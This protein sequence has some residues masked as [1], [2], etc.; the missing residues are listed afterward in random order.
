M[1]HGD[2]WALWLFLVR[3]ADSSHDLTYLMLQHSF[4]VLV[5][6][7]DYDPTCIGGW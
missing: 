1:S 5:L 4:I 7:V 6:Q 3:E 2:V